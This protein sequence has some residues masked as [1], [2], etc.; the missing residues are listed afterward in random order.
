V[1]IVDV[2]REAAIH[3]YTEAATKLYA[4]AQNNLGY[5]Y[6]V[7]TDNGMTLL[8]YRSLLD[9]IINSSYLCICIVNPD[10]LT[11]VKWFI[12]AAEQ[13]HPGALN[14]LAICYETGKGIS[15]SSTHPSYLPQ[16]YSYFDVN[17]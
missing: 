3:W 7:G 12:R 14:N 4:K 16:C 2:N 6:F 5:L 1:L 8:S 17:E 15:F 9:C 11:A 13:C 10:Y